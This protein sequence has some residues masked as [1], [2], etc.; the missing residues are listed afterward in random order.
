[1]RSIVPQDAMAICGWLVNND[2]S[3]VNYQI[4]QAFNLYTSKVR[5]HKVDNYQT[6]LDILKAMD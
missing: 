5:Y 4:T 1:M 2:Y 3:D 6:M